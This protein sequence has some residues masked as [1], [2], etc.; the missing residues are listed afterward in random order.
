MFDGITGQYFFLAFTDKAV[1]HLYHNLVS[2]Q[3]HTA[4]QPFLDIVEDTT[5]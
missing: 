2:A 4:N 3:I 1:D 5:G